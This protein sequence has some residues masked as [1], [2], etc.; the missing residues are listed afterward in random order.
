MKY[1]C[2]KLLSRK[3]CCDIT[4]CFFFLNFFY[5]L[6]IPNYRKYECLMNIYNSA[7]IDKF[8]SYEKHT[9]E[10]WSYSTASRGL[11]NIRGK[12]WIF[13]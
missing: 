6:S 1:Y 11:L 9:F 13:F 10:F 5:L 2:N 4:G 8:V 7:R 3:K 12:D